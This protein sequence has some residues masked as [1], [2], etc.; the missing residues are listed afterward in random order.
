MFGAIYNLVADFRNFW[1]LKDGSLEINSLALNNCFSYRNVFQ[2]GIN[3]LTKMVFKN[4]FFCFVLFC[5]FKKL[6][7][8]CS[9]D[10]QFCSNFTRMWSK[11]LSNN[12]WRDFRLPM[13]ALA[14]VAEK[15]FNG[16]FT[17]KIDFPLEYYILPLLLLILEVLSRTLFDKYL[18][19]MLVKFE[20]KH[21]VQ[22]LQNFE[23]FDKKWLNTFDK[24]LTPF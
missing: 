14:T 12:V 22:T 13:S 4:T 9:L 7:I 5:F 24:V 1:K 16:K 3:A 8:S 6:K 20:Q 17:A 19:H 10:I 11:Y 23:L 2:N 18:D 15:S 21:T